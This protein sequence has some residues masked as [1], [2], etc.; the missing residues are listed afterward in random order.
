MVAVFVYQFHHFDSDSI[1][2]FFLFVCK[3]LSHYSNADDDLAV[4]EKTV[5][6]PNLFS[7]SLSQIINGLRRRH[8]NVYKY[9]CVRLAHTRPIFTRKIALTPAG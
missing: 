3:Q 2:S 7:S 5:E 1:L 6:K 8:W 9:V 4:G